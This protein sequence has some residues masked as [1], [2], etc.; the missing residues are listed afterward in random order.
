MR[1]NRNMRKNMRKNEGCGLET[2]RIIEKNR[3]GEKFGNGWKNRHAVVAG[4][5]RCGIGRREYNRRGKCNER[6]EQ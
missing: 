1:P 5:K 3:S 2:G 4:E 6:G